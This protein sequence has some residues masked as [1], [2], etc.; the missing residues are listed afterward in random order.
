[1]STKPIL[2]YWKIRGFSHPIRCLLHY[3]GVDFQNKMYEYHPLPDLKKD[4]LA[5]KFKLG[6]EFPNLPYYLDEEVE[7]TE[8]IAI[9]NY[10]ATKH[11][12]SMN[13]SCYKE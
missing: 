5:E 7:L 3:V 2:G 1:M 6:I 9:F 12:P 4:W 10:I 11:D 8:S 13:G